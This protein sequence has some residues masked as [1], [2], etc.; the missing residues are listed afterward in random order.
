MIEIRTF[1]KLYGTDVK[2][3]IKEWRIQVINQGTYSVM[4]YSYGYVDGKKTECSQ[5]ISTGKNIGKSNAT[6]HYQQ[7]I[8][9]AQSKWKQKIDEGYSTDIET[10]RDRIISKKSSNTDTK[11][12]NINT[13][14]NNKSTTAK[15]VFPMLAQDYNKYK[16]KVVYP[17]YIQPKLDGYRMIYNSDTK[18][19]MSRQGKS[20]D[21]IKNSRVYDQLQRLL[22]VNIGDITNISDVTNVVF[23]GELYVHGGT[24][25]HLGILRKKQINA[26]ELEKLDQIEYHIY[27]IVDETLTY[28]QRL[29]VL[30]KL[31]RN[32][33]LS[34]I[35]L[36][37][38]HLVMDHSQLLKQHQSFVEMDYE[39]SIVRNSQGKYRCKARSQDLLKFKDFMDSEFIIVDYTSEKDVSTQA[40]PLVIWTCKTQD[41]QTFNV[42]PK[43]TREER[44][45]L[46]KRAKDFIG[47]QLHVKYFELTDAGVPRFP[48]TKSETYTSYIRDTIE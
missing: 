19:C 25:E 13:K 10:I 5:N 27:D 42:R 34:H 12:T 30:Q 24:F 20:F 6:T 35:R 37:E 39:G 21:V 43:G 31:F 4:Q 32:S 23:D 36:V 38:T 7:A 18:T 9:N 14:N 40:E 15:T 26:S 17:V 48:T 28:E 22:D 44:Q 8:A 45:M 1:E 33:E 2:N 47:H 3:K 41:N 16:N 29:R 46:Y 11:S